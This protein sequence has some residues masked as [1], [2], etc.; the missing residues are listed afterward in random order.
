MYKLRCNNEI[1]KEHNTLL[2]AKLDTL[3]TL[4]KTPSLKLIE[5]LDNDDEIVF[6]KEVK[7]PTQE[8]IEVGV[9]TV[10]RNLITRFYDDITEVESAKV[11]LEDKG[12]DAS[13][14]DIFEEIVDDLHLHIGSLE[15]CLSDNIE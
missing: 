10:I 4:K 2:E 5:V 3:L 9:D 6:Q 8:Q 11:S 14:F 1:I 15:S 7:E 12:V 13:T